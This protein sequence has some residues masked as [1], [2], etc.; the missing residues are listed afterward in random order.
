MIYIFKC[1]FIFSGKLSDFFLFF[2]SHGW[3]NCLKGGSPARIC[4][5][6]VLVS[7]HDQNV[8]CAND[9]RPNQIFGDDFCFVVTIYLCCQNKRQNVSI[10]SYLPHSFACFWFSCQGIVRFAVR[11][12]TLASIPTPI[13]VF[14]TFTFLINLWFLKLLQVPGKVVISAGEHFHGGFLPDWRNTNQTFYLPTCRCFLQR[15]M[16]TTYERTLRIV[17]CNG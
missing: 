15:N 3:L 6:Y 5:L 17:K 10:D 9:A 14:D 4:R 12:V 11:Y 13:L 1:T 8:L 16:G 2:V 7:C